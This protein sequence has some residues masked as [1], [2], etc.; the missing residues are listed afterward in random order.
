MKENIFPVSIN[1]KVV[2][3]EGRFIGS[4]FCVKS[5]S[6]DNHPELSPQEKES[7]KSHLQNDKSLLIM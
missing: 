4:K 2:N 7:L 5:S 3:L 1:D 6:I